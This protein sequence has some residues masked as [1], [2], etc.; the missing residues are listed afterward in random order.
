MTNND[1]KTASE[2]AG[3]MSPPISQQNITLPHLDFVIWIFKT[4]ENK[5]P[6]I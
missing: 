2:I 4:Y 5:F 1:Y 3:Y 6:K